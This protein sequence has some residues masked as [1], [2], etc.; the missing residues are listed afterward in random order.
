MNGHHLILGELIDFLTRKTVPDTHDERYRQK[1]AR[2]I[3]QKK[4]YHK[5]DIQSRC[6][7]RL[8]AG[9]RSAIVPVD[10]IVGL[11][12]KDAIIVKYGPGSLVTRRRS[13]LAA[14][15][16]WAPYQIPIAVITNGE[17]AEV[18]DGKGGRVIGTG[19]E[20]IP[21]REQLLQIIA[22]HDFVTVSKDRIEME[23]RIM[24]AFEVD[25]SCPC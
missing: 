6:D 3:V 4:G 17:N 11:H 24:F 18:L 23:S 14:T 19:H 16:L 22:D 15:R 1:V 8:C 2:F 25:D 10:F 21:T 7:L 20:A 5:R 13:A 12:G 9:E